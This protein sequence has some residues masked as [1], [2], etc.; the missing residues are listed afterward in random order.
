VEIWLDLRNHDSVDIPN[1]INRVVTK[2]ASYNQSTVYVRNGHVELS[3]NEQGVLVHI[4]S[5]QEQDKA[6]S[7]VGLVDWI[8]LSGED[9]TMIPFENL[10]AACQHSHTKI[11]AFIDQPQQANGAAFAL[12]TG[13]DA[14]IVAPF[15]ELIEAALIAKSI[16][17]EH[18]DS[19]KSKEEIKQDIHIQEFYLKSVESGGVG[20]RYCLDFT[21]LF[22]HHEGVFIGSSAKSMVLIKA[23]TA[24]SDFVPSRPFRVNA[25]SPHSYIHMFDGAMKYLSELTSGDI[26]AIV[27]TNGQTRPGT[28][29]RIKIERRPLLHIKFHDGKNNEGH[30]FIQQAETVRLFANDGKPISATHLKITDKVLGKTSQHGT[31]IG[32]I[33]LSDVEE[34]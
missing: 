6:L 18:D 4:T 13:V 34:K 29:G 8:L 30:I 3:T 25:G 1:G 33:V 19:L 14:L 21:T 15:N 28:I 16:R 10:V 32:N 31:H 2:D 12:Q 22:N 9:W 26:V 23:E 24:P 5:K 27:A 11:A 17:F 7:F 20:E